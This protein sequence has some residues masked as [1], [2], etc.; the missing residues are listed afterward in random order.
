MGCTMIVVAS[1]C[2]KLRHQWGCW[3]GNTHQVCKAVSYIALMT[4]LEKI[5][6]EVLLLDLTLSGLTS[7]K[8]IS[9]LRR[10]HP[11]THVIVLSASP[12]PQEELVLLKLG[13]R[14]YC[15]HNIS[16]DLLRKAVERVQ[17]GEIWVTRKL[18]PALIEE[19][20]ALNQWK[21]K[22]YKPVNDMYLAT[23]TPREREIAT[24]V[25]QGANN[26][27]IARKLDIT[28]RTVKAHLSEIFRKLSV[29]NRLQLALFMHG[30]K[31]LTI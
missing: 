11:L 2:L 20:A 27:I 26:K 22:D 24:L 21:G 12:S 19:I 17:E 1:S 7:I 18:I 3:L 16:A 10:R 13:V 14:G 28:E 30:Y 4:V 6:P 29:P 31:P 25:G 9:D 5:Q 23:L 15:S 8:S